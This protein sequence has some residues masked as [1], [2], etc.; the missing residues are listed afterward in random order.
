MSQRTEK[1]IGKRS[2]A[3]GAKRQLIL[4]AALA[5]FSQYGIHGARLEQV[6]ERAGVSKTNLL[7]Y[8]PSKEALYVAVMRQILDVWLAPLKAFRA[9]FSPLEA[10]KEYIRLK[11]EVSRDYPQASRLFCMEMLAGAPLL[12]EELTGDLKALIDEKSALIAGWVHSG[13]W[14]PFPTPFDL[15][16]LGRHAT[17][18]RFCPSG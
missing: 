10:I 13:N 4:T 7:Y 5:V 18:R 1:K 12:M 14:R 15:H 16:D 17:L 9:E 6:A 11:L 2:Q 3:T 8:Y